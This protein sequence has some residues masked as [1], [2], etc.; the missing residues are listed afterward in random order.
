MAS[1]KWADHA[2]AC[3]KEQAKYIAE[4]SQ[5]KEI[6]WKWANDV[7]ESALSSAVA[8]AEPLPDMSC[9]ISDTVS[10]A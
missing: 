7:F 6:A 5:S 2:M 10:M 3:M 1:V 4:Q 9:R 8:P